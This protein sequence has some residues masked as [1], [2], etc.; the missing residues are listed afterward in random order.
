MYWATNFIIRHL[1]LQLFSLF[2]SFSF[3]LSFFHL[4]KLVHH[5]STESNSVPRYERCKQIRLVTTSHMLHSSPAVSR[6]PGSQAS[7]LSI[8]RPTTVKVSAI[9]R[10]PTSPTSYLLSYDRT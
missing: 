10:L 5:H 8:S 6:Y 4:T 2:H 9:Y 1:F 3:S 7:S